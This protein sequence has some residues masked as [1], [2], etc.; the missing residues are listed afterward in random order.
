V[1]V[2]R[3][4]ASERLDVNVSPDSYP[5]R[6]AHPKANSVNILKRLERY[7]SAFFK[8]GRIERIAK[9]AD[10]ASKENAGRIA[11]TE[12]L[13][14]SQMQ[15]MGRT[16]DEQTAWVNGRLAEQSLYDSELSRRLDQL[17]L[18]RGFSD[19]PE[20]AHPAAEVGDDWSSPLKV[21]HQLG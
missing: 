6:T 12:A 5:Q 21:V 10:Q 13:I 19:I 11:Q 9:Q 17:F 16:I 20:D 15:N 4:I 3:P 1:Q 14:T 18:S 2:Y 7:I 8:L